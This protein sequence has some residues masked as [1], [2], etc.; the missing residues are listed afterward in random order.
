MVIDLEKSIMDRNNDV[1]SS[2]LKS[3]MGNAEK[4]HFKLTKSKDIVEK[5]DT[6]LERLSIS[7]CVKARD[8]YDYKRVYK[9]NNYRYDSLNEL[10]RYGYG[11][12]HRNYEVIISFEDSLDFIYACLFKTKRGSLMEFFNNKED[13]Y[14]MS[15]QYLAGGYINSIDLAKIK[16]F[17]EAFDIVLNNTHYKLHID[18][19]W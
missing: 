4:R 1:N 10:E 11:R 7:R 14:A 5:A 8:C 17:S 19:I 3:V 13:Y 2:S 12:F 15:R 18:V 16:G 9:H 6:Q